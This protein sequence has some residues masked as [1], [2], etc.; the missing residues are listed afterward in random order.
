MLT[1]LPQINES[2]TSTGGDMGAARCFGYTLTKPIKYTQV[3]CNPSELS[4]HALIEASIV[5]A[6]T[7]AT[8]K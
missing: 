7:T 3:H 5:Q 8:N 6:D 1:L 4:H 2:T